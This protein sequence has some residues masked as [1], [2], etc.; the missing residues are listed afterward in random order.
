M[1]RLTSTVVTRLK[2]G[3]P[4]LAEALEREGRLRAHAEEIA[5]Q[6]ISLAQTQMRAAA[7]P[8][9]NS[10]AAVGARGLAQAQAEAEL[11]DEFVPVPLSMDEDDQQ[12]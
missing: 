6:V 9:D 1:T 8:L 2:A 12:I 5:E 3:Q 7:A 10:L 4:E 11:L